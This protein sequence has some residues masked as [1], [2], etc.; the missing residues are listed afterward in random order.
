[1]LA[2]FFVFTEEAWGF[3]LRGFAMEG[4]ADSNDVDFAEGE[5]GED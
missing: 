4:V 3:V 2:L 5:D 1:M